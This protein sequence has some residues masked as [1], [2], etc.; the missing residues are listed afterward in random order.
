[1]PSTDR[2]NGESSGGS[3]T[4]EVGGIA[5][6]DTFE[7]E[8]ASGSI[9]VRLLGVN[10]P[11]QEECLHDRAAEGL[12]HHLQSGEVGLE[13]HGLDQFGRTLAYVWADDTMVNLAMVEGG[14]AIAT[15][16][17][18]SET[19]GPDL[20]AAE[21]TAYAAGIGLW[22]TTACGGSPT[23]VDLTF[24]TS[25]HNPPGPD[26][27]V[28]ELEHVIVI[29]NGDAPVDVSGWALRDESSSNR[30]RFPG[31]SIIDAG[32]DLSV[33][34][35]DRGWEPGVSPVWSNSGDMA[36]LLTPLGNVV[37]RHRYRP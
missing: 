21:E 18:D 28:L 27:E 36:L 32:A 3:I 24:D 35:G 8:T 37:A 14:L 20:L 4:G 15:T 10:A 33:S 26:D 13:P 7:F 34:S 11:E 12:M 19:W 5:D 22:A 1:M 30:F 23:G 16:P 29:N 2:T 25:G 6:G 9:T 17:G 31:G